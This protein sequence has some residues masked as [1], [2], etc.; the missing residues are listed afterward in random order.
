MK[1][2]YD[3]RKEKNLYFI[4]PEGIETDCSQIGHSS[5]VIMFLYY[6]ESLNK[7]L[8]YI[9]NI[10][11]TIDIYIVSNNVDIYGVIL[12][13]IEK[14]Q[15]RIWLVKSQN[16]GR[17]VS[18]F[19]I[20]CRGILKKYEY[21]CFV[22]DKKRKEYISKEAFEFWIDNLWGNTLGDGAYISN[23]LHI[24]ESNKEIGLLAPPEPI[25]KFTPFLYGGDVWGQDFILTQQL[26]RELGLEC[27]MEKDKPP[28]TLGMCFWARSRAL[29]K[30]LKKDWRYESFDEEPLKDDGT[31]SHAIE[32]ILGY[33]AQDAGFSTGAI[34][35]ASYAE[36]ML[37]SIQMQS[38]SLYQLLKK[39][40]GIHNLERLLEE[41]ERLQKFYEE[42]KHVYLYGAGKVGKNCLRLLRAIECEPT[43]FLVTE[44]RGCGEKV[45]GVPVK[46]IY[47]I[48]NNKEVG[49]II[50]VGASLQDE[51][52][53][54]LK[55]RGNRNY[56]KYFDKNKD[57]G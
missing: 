56:I 30:L 8:S 53:T 11:Q 26:A 57:N 41:K 24:L 43:G 31:V 20:A 51:V 18:A 52:E 34:M 48:G 44:K 47:E 32:R 54:V 1:N 40:Y 27:R 49:V 37:A 15:N 33:V 19:L 2:V 4:L 17:E 25:G 14:S 12:Q 10:V 50:T 29:E 21:I 45:E 9:D 16:R 36:K 6:E 22:H 42:N 55:A 13:Y 38:L 5:A 46:S 39:A 7:Y 3:I 28:V 35:R 23:V